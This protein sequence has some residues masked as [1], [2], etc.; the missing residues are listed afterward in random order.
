MIEKRYRIESGERHI[1]G[2]CTDPLLR[3][4]L[5]LCSSAPLLALKPPHYCTIPNRLFFLVIFR[6][7]SNRFLNA[8]WRFR[9]R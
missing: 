6:K 3:V 5:P 7:Y 4:P 1:H 2:T 9:E 8:S